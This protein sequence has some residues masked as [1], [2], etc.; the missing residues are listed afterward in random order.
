VVFTE[1]VGTRGKTRGSSEQAPPEP[2]EVFDVIAKAQQA[3]LFLAFQPGSP[4]IIDAVADALNA[5]PSLFMR[6]AV[7]APPAASGFFVAIHGGRTN[8]KQAK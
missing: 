8:G 6:G 2:T 7:T 1:H 4:S 5:R 3:V